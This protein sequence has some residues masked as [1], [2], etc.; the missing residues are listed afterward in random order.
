MIEGGVC[1]LD[2]GNRMSRTGSTPAPTVAI[3]GT[4]FGGLGMG[5]YLKQAGITKK[6]SPHTPRQNML[7]LPQ[8]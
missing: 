3:I 7:A 6:I 1:V 5:Y 4:G 2:E 8:S